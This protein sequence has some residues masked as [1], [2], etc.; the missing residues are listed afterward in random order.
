ML[1]TGDYGHPGSTIGYTRAA[2]QQVFAQVGDIAK[3]QAIIGGN[4]LQLWDLH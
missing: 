2:V 1:W 3:A 4:T